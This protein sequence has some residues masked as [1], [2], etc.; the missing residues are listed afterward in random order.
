MKSSLVNNE[1]NLDILKSFSSDY[2]KS[3]AS[4]N[5]NDIDDNGCTENIDLD[6]QQ[7]KRSLSPVSNKAKNNTNNTNP[8]P[9]FER[10]RTKNL[11][12]LIGNLKVRKLNQSGKEDNGK[13]DKMGSLYVET[14]LSDC[15]RSTPPLSSSSPSVSPSSL[16]I[17]PDSPIQSHASSLSSSSS[18][19]ANA[20]SSNSFNTHKSRYS[21]IPKFRWMM[22]TNGSPA[23]LN[24]LSEETKA[25]LIANGKYLNNQ[26]LNK[27]NSVDEEEN[28]DD[29]ENELEIDN[30]DE[31]NNENENDFDSTNNNS[32]SISNLV[33][34]NKNIINNSKINAAGKPK[35]ET[36]NIQRN[37]L[38][39]E[40]NLKAEPT[41]NEVK[42]PNQAPKLTA[43]HIQNKN[44]DDPSRAVKFYDDFI[45]FRGDIL[46]RPPNSKN[47]RI[48]W[49]YLYLLLQDNN[50]SSVIKWEDP[51][52]M[53]FRIV[54][55]EKL[56]ALWGLQKNR[57]GM[58]YEK[59]S[60]GM[61]YYY[62]NNIIAREPGRRLLYRFMRHPD[63]IK[64]FVKKNGTYML[65]RAK[66]STKAELDESKAEMNPEDSGVDE[67]DNKT[68]KASKAK[69]NKA[70]NNSKKNQKNNFEECDEVDGDLLAEDEEL[71]ENCDD[72]EGCIDEEDDICND[73]ENKNT[74]TN[75]NKH[76]NN[77]NQKSNKLNKNGDNKSAT[78]LINNLLSSASSVSSSSSSSSSASS[79]SSSP[80][81]PSLNTAMP[82]PQPNF[83]S[84]LYPYMYSAQMAYFS[85]L[86]SSPNDADAI[87]M[88]LRNQVEMNNNLLDNRILNESL[89]TLAST[90]SN[91]NRTSTNTSNQNATNGNNTNDLQSKLKRSSNKSEVSS[92]YSSASSTHSFDND[93]QSDE[94][95][96]SKNINKQNYSN[97]KQTRNDN[98]NNYVNSQLN[99][100]N[101]NQKHSFL[102]NN[103][104]EHPL[105]LSM[106]QK[107][108]RKS[109]YDISRFNNLN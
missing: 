81:L 31:N 1:N 104:A 50:Y 53:V 59:L 73:G 29:N 30:E 93:R 9:T 74:N 34:G 60:R 17:P 63:E 35:L 92:T 3:N 11:E 7:R 103:L 40:T 98:S 99:D 70:A 69:A 48:L 22:E 45:D 28:D 67:P 58:T 55:A 49:E 62:P 46:R 86:M 83:Y 44:S 76:V 82:N 78:E 89:Q 84:E 65:K 102:L 88:Q 72:M 20:S 47:C 21:M 15:S 10:K 95:Y 68:A 106:N 87:L 5:D 108:Q 77:T 33:N 79:S 91:L 66:M 2:I 16:S 57:L 24:E 13:G 97:T 41:V 80:P 64:K 52:N 37:K 27:K 43:N 107:K 25:M 8:T 19:L 109:K 26:H 42:K 51:V 75:N 94:F 23:N 39:K 85:R 32:W 36:A 6:I 18:S 90:F 14:S 61:R 54:Q 12:N 101:D 96:N 38:L 100:L 4:D 56:A 71:D 105:N